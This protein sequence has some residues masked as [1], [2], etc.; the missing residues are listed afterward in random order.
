[1]KMLGTQE[2]FVL[3]VVA[4]AIS[5]LIGVTGLATEAGMWYALKQQNKTATDAAAVSAAFE[6]AGHVTT[7]ATTNPSGAEPASPAATNLIPPRRTP[8]RST[9]LY[10]RLVMLIAP[11]RSF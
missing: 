11:S 4:V 7:G 10:V 3:A 5:A 9:H 8:S 2:G 6:Y 1:M